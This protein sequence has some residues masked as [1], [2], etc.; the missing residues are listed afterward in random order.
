MIAFNI[1]LPK[2]LVEFKAIHDRLPKSEEEFQKE[3]I[4][5]YGI[6]LP[7]LPMGDRYVYN[8]KTGELMVEH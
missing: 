4:E 1:Q 8:V 6:E 5:K 7:E 2:A 3:I